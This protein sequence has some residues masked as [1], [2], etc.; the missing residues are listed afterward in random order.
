MPGSLLEAINV[1]IVD[2]VLQMCEGSI[3]LGASEFNHISK[4][5]AVLYGDDTNDY[6]LTGTITNWEKVSWWSDNTTPAEDPEGTGYWWTGNYTSL[7]LNY[8]DP[9]AIVHA[10]GASPEGMLYF[11]GETSGATVDITDFLVILQGFQ[12]ID[13]YTDVIDD[14]FKRLFFAYT[15]R[16]QN[17]TTWDAVRPDPRSTGG[18]SHIFHHNDNT[19]AVAD[20]PVLYFVDGVE[21][22]SIGDKIQVD[23]I[24]GTDPTF[25]VARAQLV[26]G[27]WDGGDAEGWLYLYPQSDSS[28]D[29]SISVGYVSSGNINNL[30]TAN[31]LGVTN[32]QTAPTSNVN[33]LAHGLLWKLDTDTRVNSGWK[34]IDMGYS[35][36]F[37]NGA[38]APLSTESPVFVTDSLEVV[39][40]T[41]F[42]YMTSPATE[43]PLTG[44][45]SAWAGLGNVA[46]DDATYATTTL[47]IGDN[48]RN[49]VL[50]PAVNGLPGDAKIIGIEVA[51]EASV[52]A[53][54]SAFINKV[55]LRKGTTASGDL[56]DVE[57]YSADR[58][59]NAVLATTPGTH[60]YR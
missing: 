11:I 17:S 3:P 10:E 34:Y 39:Q 30:T 25:Y 9:I 15:G 45:F 46:A 18:I 29:S 5:V 6:T 33:E 47:A 40:E 12:Y 37:D 8:Q 7:P 35:V 57:Y 50:T 60:T 49:M 51:F 58:A 27:S 38:I 23:K 41:G 20:W 54:S 21:E 42:S 22:P 32:A 4:K 52:S 31:L 19:Y 1:E 44:T 16:T 13:Q 48:S 53:G 24:V 14:A 2:G 36:Q 59:D 43:F 26:T 56:K 55:Q 28:L